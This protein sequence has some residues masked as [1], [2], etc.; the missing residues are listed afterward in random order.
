MAPN[1]KAQ[2]D[3]MRKVYF[4]FGLDPGDTAYVEVSSRFWS[5]ITNPIWTLL[6]D[7]SYTLA[8]RREKLFFRSFSVVNPNSK[9]TMPPI[10]KGLKRP[11]VAVAF[12]GKGA[13]WARMRT[14]S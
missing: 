13:Q 14:N 8:M 3:L 10:F 4:D 12:G 5:Q 1:G 9:M 6:E 7:L 11:G 2:E